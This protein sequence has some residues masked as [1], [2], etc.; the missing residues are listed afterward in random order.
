MTRERSIARMTNLVAPR[1]L[2]LLERV[3]EACPQVPFT[4][5]EDESGDD[6]R[7]GMWHERSEGDGVETYIESH[8]SEEYG[9]RSGGVTFG[10]HIVGWG[11][12]ILGQC[13]PHNYSPEVW[14]PRNDLAAVDAR[15]AELESVDLSGVQ[16]MILDHLARRAA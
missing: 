10:L 3:R 6:V 13:T 12:E 8:L 14:V 4:I 7:W 15:L 9:D 2:A 16:D 11:G 5:P 1:A